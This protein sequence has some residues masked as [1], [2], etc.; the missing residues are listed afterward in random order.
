MRVYTRIDGWSGTLFCESS[1]HFADVFYNGKWI[2]CTYWT[3]RE[4]KDTRYFRLVGNNF[5]LK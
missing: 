5:K 3:N 4:L 1:G 2:K